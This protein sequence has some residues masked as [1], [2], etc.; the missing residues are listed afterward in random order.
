M[1]DET[2]RPGSD[3]P[4]AQKD[5]SL[6]QATEEP[7]GDTPQ[8]EQN[9]MN[10][11]RETLSEKGKKAID[12]LSGCKVLRDKYGSKTDG[13]I[14]RTI[15]ELER[16]PKAASTNL[17][18]ET[19]RMSKV[20]ERLSVGF[21]SQEAVDKETDISKAFREVNTLYLQENEMK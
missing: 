4:M 17:Y 3:D 2:L 14:K 18:L 9:D 13:I 20:K 1:A 7:T 15:E 12:I 10:E 21:Y 19:N 6:D 16:N 11:L 8:V 5:M